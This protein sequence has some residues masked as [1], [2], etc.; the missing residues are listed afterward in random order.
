MGGKQRG[1][2]VQAGMPNGAIEDTPAWRSITIEHICSSQRL[3]PARSTTT[4]QVQVTRIVLV[5][6]HSDSCNCC[7]QHQQLSDVGL[8]LFT[9]GFEV[10]V[11]F[12]LT[13]FDL[14][15]PNAF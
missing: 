7:N 11:S 6:L 2:W 9:S 1:R 5:I 10:Q 13:I 14:I 8:V 15:I 3:A 4:D 12:K